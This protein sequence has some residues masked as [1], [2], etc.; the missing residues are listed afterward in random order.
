MG[1]KDIFKD[2]FSEKLKDLELPVNENLWN[3]ISNQIVSAPATSSISLLSK[4]IIGSSISAAAIVGGYYLNSTSENNEKQ[5]KSQISVNKN[6]L[7]EVKEVKETI[8]AIKQPSVSI[9]KEEK[10][11]ASE[12]I[13]ADDNLVD[14]LVNNNLFISPNTVTI[15]QSA[16]VTNQNKND[17]PVNNIVPQSLTETPKATVVLTETKNISTEE[18]TVYKLDL[19]NVFTPNG[20]GV[21][22][23]LEIETEGL[24]DFSV[25]ILDKNNQKIYTSNDPYFKWDGTNMSGE[26]VPEGNYI[27]FVT[28]KT[29]S[30]KP[31]SK[32]SS[33]TIKR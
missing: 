20:D 23:Y 26:F 4:I 2:I 32:Y 21:N 16:V 13:I 22:D 1:D 25:V 15:N 24:S 3:S 29:E 10:S 6:E 11:I 28:A 9:N 19:K 31:I 27:Y 14:I 33:L 7:S 12:T 5:T 8:S 17:Q 30:N 18:K